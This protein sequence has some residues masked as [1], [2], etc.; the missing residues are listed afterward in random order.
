MGLKSGVGDD[1]SEQGGS[2][3]EQSS[4]EPEQSTDQ[5]EQGEQQNDGRP[6]IVRR[7]MQGKSAQFERDDRLNF[8]VHKDIARGEYNL[9][10][11]M[12]EALVPDVTKYD[13]REAVYRTA[14]NHPEDVR[15][16]LLAMGYSE[17]DD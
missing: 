14:L 3:D 10:G 1:L 16:E 6:Y 5:E 9:L 11:E 12:D 15:Q 13:L 8:F 7:A 4:P 17:S 2:E